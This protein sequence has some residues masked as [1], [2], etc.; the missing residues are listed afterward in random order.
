MRLAYK[1]ISIIITTL[2]LLTI[3]QACSQNTRFSSVPTFLSALK[4]EASGNGGTY[5]GKI[6][7]L[8][9]YVDDFTCEGKPRP[10][11][12]LMRDQNLK[13]SLIRNTSEKCAFVNRIEATP[14]DYNE[15]TNQ[16]IYMNDV[17]VPP[18]DYV[19]SASEDPNLPGVKPD[20]GVCE[21][22]NGICSLRAALD[23]ADLTALTT[24]VI[25]HV[26]AGSYKARFIGLWSDY[27]NAKSITIRGEDPMTTI[28]DGVNVIAPLS[29]NRKSTALVAIENITVQNGSGPVGGGS[30]AAIDTV[31]NSSAIA[32]NN[33]IIKNTTNHPALDFAQDASVQ[34]RHTIFYGNNQGAV[35]IYRA[36]TLIEDSVF[37]STLNAEGLIMWSNKSAVVRRSTFSNNYLAISLNVCETCQLENITVANNRGGIQI[38]G[39]SS[40]SI[41][42]STIVNNSVLANGNLSL[43]PV[44]S[45]DKLYFNNSVLATNDPTK[46]NCT[47]LAS[48]KAAA[49]SFIA[50]NSLIDDASCGV[51]NPPNIMASPML[52]PLADNGGLTMTMMP[53][54]GSPLINAGSD[55]LCAATDQ[56]GQL[57]L[58][59]DIGSV[60]AP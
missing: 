15:V 21:D 31:R 34:I 37:E 1:V 45:S 23:V 13:W 35:R 24:P 4:N 52:G 29:I 57:H 49:F 36:A 38:S 8:H 59:C 43:Y 14:V 16:A 54:P 11:S 26:L 40:N 60:E 46:S 51:L 53:Q 44:T 47:W 55:A 41:T 2:V 18:R 3:G 22:S 5:D 17:Y 19:V 27:S 50:M 9:H 7:V 39:G 20:T 32:I 12:I 58:K 28:L 42:N 25:I 33:C 6:R 10:E 56:R 30:G 48:T